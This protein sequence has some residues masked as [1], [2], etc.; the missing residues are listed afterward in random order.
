VVYSFITIKCKHRTQIP[1]ISHAAV[2]STTSTHHHHKKKV[3]EVLCITSKIH[4]QS[5][6]LNLLLLSGGGGRANVETAILTKGM[7]G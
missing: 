7:M 3:L 4:P 1:Q 5:E 2:H 6:F